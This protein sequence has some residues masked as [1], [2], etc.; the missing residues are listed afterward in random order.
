MDLQAGV[1]VVVQPGASKLLVL[2][3]ESEGFDEVQPRAG[4]GSEADRVAGVGRN[5]R[6]VQ[7]HI[8]IECLAWNGRVAHRSIL[9]TDGPWGSAGDA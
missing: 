1:L 8:Q 5:L 3:V 6:L 9:R 4:V 2:Q 7:Q